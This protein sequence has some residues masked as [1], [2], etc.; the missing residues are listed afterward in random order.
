MERDVLKRVEYLASNYYGKHGEIKSIA[1]KAAAEISRLRQE[2][3]RLILDVGDE[4]QDNDELR[5][6]IATLHDHADDCDMAGD[7]RCGRNQQLREI[8]NGKS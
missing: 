4:K 2:N 8:T 6:L 3:A 7:C 1:T 5:N